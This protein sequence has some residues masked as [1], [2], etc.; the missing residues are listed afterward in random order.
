M[1]ALLTARSGQTILAVD[2]DADILAIVGATLRS[3]GYEVLTARS[4]EEGMAVIA[5]KGLPH[6]AVV[7][8][9]MPEVDGIEFCK[10]LHKFCD[11]PVIML[12]AVDS[13]EMLIDT[14]RDVAED[15][16]T[17]PFAPPELVVRVERVLRRIGDLSYA[18]S[19]IVKIDHRL[20]VSFTEQR[21]FVDG[22][23]IPL[24][25]TE[26][27]ILHVMVRNRGRTVAT[28]FLL[29]RIWP[30][31]EVFEDSLRVHVHRL[32]QKMEPRVSKPVY[33]ITKRG[34]GYLFQ[35]DSGSSRSH[36]KY[37]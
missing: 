27:K 17:K 33:I 5:E 19:P 14:M 35:S 7:D 21:I 15:Y 36:R 2:D 34:V 3:A 26:C 32:R 4:A 20:S 31:E 12:T 37:P 23:S 30:M 8:I 11:L 18:L 1:G 25:P 28:D 10:S 29:R 24:T 16:I 9:M 22:E 13:Q 6:L